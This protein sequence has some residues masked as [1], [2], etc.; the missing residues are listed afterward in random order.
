MSL[1]RVHSTKYLGVTIDQH[2]KWAM[3]IDNIIIRVRK[4]F[5]IQRITEFFKYKHP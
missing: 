5:Y 1:K 3:H 4:C 2:L